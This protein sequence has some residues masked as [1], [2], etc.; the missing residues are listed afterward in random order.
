MFRALAGALILHEK[1]RTTDTKAKE[2]RRV[3]ERLITRAR[4]LG[5]VAE[6]DPKDLS[7]EDLARRLHARRVVARFLPRFG[8][9]TNAEGDSEEVDLLEKLFTDLGPR[10]RDRDGGYTRIVKVG[11]RRVR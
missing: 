1:I 5:E 10:F 2:L 8:E 7:A 6:A 9:K 11:P 3:V 4:R